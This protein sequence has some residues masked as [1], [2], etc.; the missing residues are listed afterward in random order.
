VLESSACEPVSLWRN[1]TEPL[2]VQQLEACNGA[3]RCV[4]S[5]HDGLE[6]GVDRRLEV[7]SAHGT[8]NKRH[9]SWTESDRRN[10]RG[11]LQ[12]DS[13]RDAW[14]GQARDEAGQT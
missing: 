1:A 10:R 12:L 9:F 6:G 2:K 11:R 13:K 14:I 3:G 5:G 8:R 7:H 4:E